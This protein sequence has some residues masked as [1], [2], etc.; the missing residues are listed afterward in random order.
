MVL[1]GNLSL[2]NEIEKDEKHRKLIQNILEAT[3]LM[4][5]TIEELKDLSPDFVSKK[6]PVNLVEI[7]KKSL[8]FLINGTKIVYEISTEEPLSM[9]YGDSGQIYRIFQNIIVNAKQ[10]MGEEG[11]IILRLKNLFNEGE[12]LGLSKGKFVFISITDIGPGIPEEYIDKIFDPFFTIKKEGK[13]LGL[14]IVRNIIEKI[15]GK[16]EV[17]SKLGEGTTFKIYLPALE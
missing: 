16:I 10:A 4:G 1:T 9:V 15:G 5:N 3:K 2:L 6:E 13:G 7:A 14:S 12:I 11:K 17:E 8:D